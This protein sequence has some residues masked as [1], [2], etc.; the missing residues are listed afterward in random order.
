MTISKRVLSGS[1][2]RG[3]RAI[4]IRVEGEVSGSS[5]DGNIITSEGWTTKTIDQAHYDMGFLCRTNSSD[6][7]YLAGKPL[8]RHFDDTIGSGHTPTGSYYFGDRVWKTYLNHVREERDLGQ[9]SLYADSTPFVEMTDPTN[10][11]DIISVHPRDLYLPVSMVD[12]NSYEASDGIIEPFKIRKKIDHSNIDVPFALEGIR[13]SLSEEDPFRKS[14]LFA[15]GFNRNESGVVP[16]LDAP[17]FFGTV[18][19]PS[20]FNEDNKRIT[21]FSDTSHYREIYFSEKAK[22]GISVSSDIRSV[23]ISGSFDTSDTEPFDSYGSRGA[24]YI[25]IKTDSIAFGGL[26][27]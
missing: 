20:I 18:E 1:Q 2:S 23:L 17:E 13:A 3:S 10:P 4:D 8:G 5:R 6:S 14:V 27:K 11:I 9:T 24:D 15:E 26:L 19:L 16:F 12:F 25:D 7:I 21:P 22:Y